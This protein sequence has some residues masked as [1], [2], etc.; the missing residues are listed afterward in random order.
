MG[1]ST[2]AILVYGI[3]LCDEEGETP[4]F[5]Q[6]DDGDEIEFDD[7]L[8]NDAGYAPWGWDADDAVCEP[9]EVYSAR[10][11]DAQEQAGVEL[12]T[13]C[14]GDY[15]M[16]ILAVSGAG[17]SASRGIPLA[18]DVPILNMNQLEGREKLRVFCKCHDI[19]WVEPKWMLCS[20][21]G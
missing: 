4:L 15:P 1:V 18:V 17:M 2:D 8:L 7:V 10:R 14:S 13:H 19:P 12:V 20:Y 9:Y 11:K 5:M 21:W 3:D 6:N 16:Y